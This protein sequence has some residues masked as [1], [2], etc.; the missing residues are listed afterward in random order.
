MHYAETA[1]R[2]VL[3]EKV[4][5][6]ISQISQESTCVGVCNF[7]KKVQHKEKEQ[8]NRK[9]RKFGEKFTKNRIFLK[10]FKRALILVRLSSLWKA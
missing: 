4:F 6:K 5:V 7:S 2:G 9:T 3:S 8:I 10:F 1:T